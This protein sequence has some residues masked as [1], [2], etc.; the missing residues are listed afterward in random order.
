M[1]LRQERIVYFDFLLIHCFRHFRSLNSSGTNDVLNNSSEENKSNSNTS[2][3]TNNIG[4]KKAA[5][6][7]ISNSNRN[8][9]RKP[10]K[11]NWFIL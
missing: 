4:S 2:N 9:Q 11:N 8:N 3:E 1:I 10:Y 5:K 6:N 7:N